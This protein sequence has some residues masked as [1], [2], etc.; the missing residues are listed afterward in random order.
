M[1]ATRDLKEYEAK[2]L[3]KNGDTRLIRP[4]GHWTLSVWPGGLTF[5][6]EF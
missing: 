1:R 3:G 5:R 6:L 4:E 2:Y